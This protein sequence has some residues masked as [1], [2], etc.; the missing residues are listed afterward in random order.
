MTRT[1]IAVM[2]FAMFLT[3]LIDFPPY[4]IYREGERRG[5]PL[6]LYHHS[7][8]RTSMMAVA[9]VIIEQIIE[10]TVSIISSISFLFLTALSS[11]CLYNTIS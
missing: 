9:L 11:L 3:V 8:N 4:R 10:R 5:F 7:S 2:T 1:A 6:S